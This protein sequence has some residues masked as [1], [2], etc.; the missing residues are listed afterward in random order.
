MKNYFVLVAIFL[1]GACTTNTPDI[2][3]RAGG[4]TLK[5][6]SPAE[7]RACK[8]KKG[9]VKPGYIAETCVYPTKDAGKSCN[10]WNQC[11]AGCVA[12]EG[13][14]QNDPVTGTC[15]NLAG[16]GGCTNWVDGGYATGKICS[17]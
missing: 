3:W 6:M 4:G 7:V 12:P 10:D 15:K 2:P 17:D 1:L 14:K 9:K 11:E 5:K 16:A 13:A 8:A